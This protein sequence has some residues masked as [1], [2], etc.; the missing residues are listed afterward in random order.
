MFKVKIEAKD[1][2]A[3][4]LFGLLHRHEPG[5]RIVFYQAVIDKVTIIRGDLKSMI[6]TDTQ[7]VDLAIR[8]LD[9]KGKPAQVDGVPVWTSSDETICKVTPAADGLSC[10]AAATVNLGSVQISVSAD[11]DLGAGVETISGILDIDIVAGKAVSLGVITG[12]PREQVV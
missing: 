3:W 1:V 8:P 12:T 6:L 9:R 10:V 5:G 11:A 2:D 4:R 7:E